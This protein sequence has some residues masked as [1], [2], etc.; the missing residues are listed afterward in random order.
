MGR[1][2]QSV[3]VLGVALSLMVIAACGGASSSAST[4]HVDPGSQ[5]AGDRSTAAY[6]A[7][8]VVVADSG[9]RSTDHGFGFEN[10]GNVLPNGGAAAN[11]TAEDVRAM[12]GDAV[13][14]DAS[15]ARC[16]LIPEARAWLDSTN[17]E[18]A[19][20]HC[21]GFSVAAEMLWQRTLDVNAYGASATPTLVI[22]DNPLLQR[23][24][25]YA[26]ALQL[27]H[28][29][30]SAEIYGPPYSI[31]NKLTQV[32]R[33]NPPE[34]YTIGIFKRDGT[35]GHAVTP[36]AVESK[37][38][39]RFDVLIYDNNWPGVTRAIAFDTKANTW[40]Y[41]AAINPGH[42]DEIYS[43]DA[44]TRNISLAPTSPGLGT[45]PCPFCHRRL[46]TLGSSTPGG[47]PAHGVLGSSTAGSDTEEIYLDGSDTNHADL[48]VTDQA[49]RRVGYVG[50]RLVDEIPGA[51]VVQLIA[52]RD[53]DTRIPPHFIVPADAKYAITIDGRM[54]PT[55]D[56][57]TIRVIG[58][59]YDVSVD[60]IPVKPGDKDVL[61]V[62][63]NGTNLSYRA[64][65]KE[66]PTVEIGVSDADAHYAFTV[67]GVA[68]RPGA[69]LRFGIPVDGGI[70]TIWN[71]RSAPPSSVTVQM[72]RATERGTQVFTHRA[73]RLDGGERAELQF[74]KW[75]GPNDA[76]P[77]VN[78]T[79]R[80]Q[81]VQLLTN[82]TSQG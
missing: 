13:C 11:M 56:T 62:E 58:P 47:G 57:E 32:L 33:P 2:L 64:S 80:A 82:E 39:G 72:T 78:M 77:L 14:A 23:R 74:G 21:Y 73:L 61:V 75:T 12:F 3:G 66:S 5:S 65:R 4:P 51:Q 40:M 70:L 42:P 63:P 31:L 48:L 46:R 36:Y 26:W 81:S 37:G 79:T 7:D 43:G 9:F 15:A 45:Q 24:I 44:G 29:V 53:W 49:G 19:G 41:D 68:D 67:A 1:R 27:L 76:L 69:T 59:S 28:S 60:D 20:G 71:G 54:L 10:Y 22:D 16:D 34:T 25:A 17:K 18:M 38:G 30:Q 50:R 55:N 35:G 52:N 6:T 8:G